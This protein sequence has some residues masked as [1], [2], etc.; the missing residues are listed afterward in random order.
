[1]AREQKFSLSQREAAQRIPDAEVA[2]VPAV[3][4]A[5]RALAA[6]QKAYQAALQPR[7]AAKQRLDELHAE[8]AAVHQQIEEADA[9]RAEVA[10]AVTD[11]KTSGGAFHALC[12]MLDEARLEAERIELSMPALEARFHAH[13]APTERAAQ[14]ESDATIA[15]A[16]AIQAAKLERAVASGA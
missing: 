13:S 12:Q 5:R 15:L 7:L 10:L 14:S 3:A 2:N 11:G 16:D 8:L 9:R 1:M 4:A 6:A